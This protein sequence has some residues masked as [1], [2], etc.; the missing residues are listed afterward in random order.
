[1]LIDV[2]HFYVSNNLKR[3]M[4]SNINEAAMYNC[5]IYNKI[6]IALRHRCEPVTTKI[7]AFNSFRKAVVV[8]NPVVRISL[9]GD[10]TILGAFSS[11]DN[12]SVLAIET[13]PT[14]TFVYLIV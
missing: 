9:A 10:K 12:Q 5:R 3:Q 2:G 14:S 1:M 13:S 8:S 6:F 11:M 4:I 7:N